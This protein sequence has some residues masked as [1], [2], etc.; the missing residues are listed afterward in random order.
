MS[1][2][3]WKNRI[4]IGARSVFSCHVETVVLLVVFMAGCA[5]QA[6]SVGIPKGYI[7]KEEHYDKDGFQDYTDYAKYIYSSKDIIVNDDKYFE[8][9]TKSGEKYLHEYNLV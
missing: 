8:K 9:W 7:E 4:Y 6:D 2:S 1:K 3:G 5:S